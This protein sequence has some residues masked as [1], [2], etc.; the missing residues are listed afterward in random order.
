M[1][2]AFAGATVFDGTSLQPNAV[3]LVEEGRVAGLADRVPQGAHLTTF[4]GGILAPGFLDLQVN[5]GGGEMVGATTDAAQIA[6]L[7]AVHGGL[8]ATGILPTLITDTPEVT[9]RV[10]AAAGQAVGTPGFLG[11]HLE[12]P[13]LDRR[14]KGAHDA[15]HIRPMTAA[16]LALYAGAARHLPALMITLAPSSVTP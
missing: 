15:V 12:G 14:R 5:G 7:C 1:I 11:L 9:A 4:S 10:L 16:D 13:H 2:Q 6:R 3:L 8:G